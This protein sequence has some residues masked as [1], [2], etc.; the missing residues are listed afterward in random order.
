MKI[1]CD[2]FWALILSLSYEQGI[3]LLSFSSPLA[4]KHGSLI[5]SSS[6][7]IQG[8]SS[9][10]KKLNHDQIFTFWHIWFRQ[11]LGLLRH[12][13]VKIY[14]NCFWTSTGLPFHSFLLPRILSQKNK[15]K[16]DRIMPNYLGTSTRWGIHYCLVWCP[17]NGEGGW[18]WES[19]WEGFYF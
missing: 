12:G 6:R 5:Q 1:W 4:K 18:G 7:L 17:R 2:Q 15:S 14:L 13:R 8:N 19:N 16:S 3:G 11:Q 10:V 9:H